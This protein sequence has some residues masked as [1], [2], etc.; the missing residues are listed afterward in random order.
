MHD[1][2]WGDC[3]LA[4]QRSDWPGF[5][6]SN[7]VVGSAQEK[8][9]PSNAVF[10]ENRWNQPDAEGDL[11]AEPAGPPLV[12]SACIVESDVLDP[13]TA[14]RLLA[15]W[16]EKLAHSSEPVTVEIIGGKRLRVGAPDGPRLDAWLRAR[17]APADYGRLVFLTFGR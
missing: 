6:I 15:G 4:S 1:P 13:S 5:C 14:E 11:S 8:R 2:T 10:F 16:Q 17:L 7:Q 12:L 3:E 9:D